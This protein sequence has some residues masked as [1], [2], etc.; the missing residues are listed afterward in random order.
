MGWKDNVYRRRLERWGRTTFS[1]INRPDADNLRV[2]VDHNAVMQHLT[3]RGW[4]MR[5]LQRRV[6]KH[7]LFA[8]RLKSWVHLEGPRWTVR[9]FFA[10]A[11]VLGVTPESLVDLDKYY[12]PK[13]R[14][15][16]GY[17]LAFGAFR[18]GYDP[19]GDAVNQWWSETNPKHE[20]A[21]YRY[22]W[23]I[24]SGRA[25]RVKVYDLLV[26]AQNTGVSMAELF[27]PIRMV[28]AKKTLYARAADVVSALLPDDMALS[29]GVMLLLEAGVRDDERLMEGF[30][31]LL[32]LRGR[33]VDF[34]TAEHE[35]PEEAGES[36][37]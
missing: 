37:G 4:A 6:T 10:V 3:T 35:G 30:Q 18:K 9:R 17:K 5:H 14:M 23:E 15:F 26:T 32:K 7:P 31:Y 27:A 19:L 16:A 13:S 1:H 22:E 21:V 33:W 24:L 36:S 8:G 34:G 11:D 12:Q 25:K 29:L 28:G 2:Y 20:A